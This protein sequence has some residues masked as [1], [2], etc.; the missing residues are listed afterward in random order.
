MSKPLWFIVDDG[1]MFEGNAH[2]FADCFGGEATEE[3]IRDYCEYQRN[4]PVRYGND[5]NL[6]V[7]DDIKAIEKRF[8]DNGW[9]LVVINNISQSKK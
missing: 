1:D 8:K 5:W 3:A 7:L 6:V 9:E 4:R 2:Q